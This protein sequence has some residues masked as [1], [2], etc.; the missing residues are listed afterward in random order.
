[1]TKLHPAPEQPESL[2]TSQQP[3]GVVLLIDEIDKA[4]PDL[5]NGLLETLGQY[6]FTVPYLN[7][8]SLQSELKNPIRADRERLL[9]VITTNEERE[10]PSAFVRRCLVHT[11]KME[12]S[13]EQINGIEKRVAWLIARAR[14]HFGSKI[15]EEVY[16]KA[17]E[18]L[19]QD[20]TSGNYSRYP[21]GLAEYIDLL[22]AL[23]GLEPDEQA[24]RLE[25]IASYTLKK[26][27]TE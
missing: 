8:Q 21:P 22:K 9:I 10:L 16:R 24:R 23:R 15:S 12:E 27:V 4:E 3:H 11:L 2:A 25:K 5:P 13:A 19:W 1:M 7:Q 6:Q 17:A 26:E 18:L 20:R 14:L